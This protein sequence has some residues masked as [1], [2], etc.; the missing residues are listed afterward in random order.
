MTWFVYAVLSAFLGSLTAILEKKTLTTLHAI[1]FSIALAFAAA[2]FSSP[3]L[4]TASWE[5]ITPTVLALTL[6]ISILS[7]FA[8]VGV[9]R[10]MRHLEISTSSPLFLMGPF[11]TVLLAYLLIGETLAPMQ[12]WGIL[13]LAIGIYVLETRHLLRAGEF[14]QHLWGDK[15][16]RFIMFGLLL[17]AGSA[18]C[19]RIVLAYLN[20]P[21]PLFIALAQV[22]LAIVFIG[23]AYYY[24]GGIREPL[25]LSAPHWKSILFLALLAMF[26]R[27]AQ[28]EATALA[29]IGLVTAVKRTSALFTTVIGGEIFHDQYILRKTIACFI[30]IGGVY[31]IALK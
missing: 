12:L 7:A 14:W 9:S 17:Y 29:A 6:L 26:A 2:L 21:A 31:L 16:S 5:S 3:I 25:R 19:D 1:D 10:G 30:M 24:R 27:I 13:L 20:V 15:Y 28:A 18:V 23:I 4:F 8:F 11:M 22:F